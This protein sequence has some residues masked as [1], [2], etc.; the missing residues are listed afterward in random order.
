MTNEIIDELENLDSDDETRGVDIFIEPPGSGRVSDG[1]SGD[2]ED[3]YFHH[4]SR[5]QLLAPASIILRRPLAED[6][7]SSEDE[8]LEDIA[9]SSLV[10][11]A[12]GRARRM[13][14]ETSRG[15][16]QGTA[17]GT[18]RETA[19]TRARGRSRGSN[20]RRGRGRWR[21]TN[22]EHQAGGRTWVKKDLPPL[23][24]EW[25]IPLPR[26]VTILCEN[27]D[28]VTFFE[29]FFNRDVIVY[30]VR[31]TVIYAV[32]SG[33]T[34]FS[35]SDREMYCFI[36]ILILSGYAPLP[37][38]RMYW[39]SNKDTHNILVADSMRRNRFEEIM[40]YFHVA[41]NSELS[42]N[43]KMAKVRPLIDMLNAKFLQ[44]APIEKEISIDESMVP[45]YGRHG[46]KQHIRG[47][48]IRFGFKMWIAATRLGYC[49]IVDP[50]QGRSERVETGLGRYVIKKL[51][52]KVQE[53]YPDTVFSVYC[54]NFFTGLPLVSELKEKNVFLTGTVR[55]NRIE[56]CPLKDMKKCQK[57][58]RGYYDYQLDET[59]G[60]CAVR[61]HDNSVVTLL[62][63]EHG[64]QPMQKAKRY[65]AALK[66]R[67]DI[68][69]PYLISQYNQYMGGVDR[70][71]AN[72]GVYRIAMRGKKWYT[73]I[74]FWLIDVAVNN[75]TLLAR[76]YRSDIDTLE[77]RRSITRVWLQNYG[78][79]KLQPGPTRKIQTTVPYSV[80]KHNSEHMI[81]KAVKRLRCAFCKNKTVTACTKCGVNLHAKCF[82]LFHS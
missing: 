11:K 14:C 40:R 49:L 34:K 15:M 16:A 54:D 46:C 3:V 4:L 32:Q 26:S 42:E 63:S 20:R 76:Q 78:N 23:N 24:R 2:E 52:T 79:E 75:A 41:N 7:T 45:Y 5:R 44:Y 74:L 30:L 64:V 6:T 82:S 60:I 35:L 70:L 71:D 17:R 10:V 80:R 77:F 13:A 69:Q 33:N 1:D 59:N 56:N 61:W 47:K 38:R 81:E 27:T 43:D 22:T 50:Y 9:P 57:E 36:G 48:P 18:V 53:E 25:N 29:M 66:S 62:S 51:I 28:P 72:V 58:E 67:I 21:E 31:Q 8:E 39:E 55:N 73:P 12:G 65:S 37:R 68:P 19:R